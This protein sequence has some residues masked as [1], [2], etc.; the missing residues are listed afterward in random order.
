[1]PNNALPKCV[2]NVLK[3]RAF[4]SLAPHFFM[5]AFPLAVQLLSIQVFNLDS[6]PP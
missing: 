1:M 3:C 5:R 6:F 4:F 2:E